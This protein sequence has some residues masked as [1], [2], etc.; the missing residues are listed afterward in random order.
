[1]RRPSGR[2]SGSVAELLQL[3]PLLDRRPAELS[4]GQQ[5]R[6]A[7]ARALVKDA[8]LVLLDEPLANLDYKLREGLRDELPRLFAD[9]GCTVVYA[10]AEPSEALL[11]GGH[12]ATLH[13]GR[14]TQFGPTGDVYRR[15]VDLTTAQVFSDPPINT[16]AV[17]KQGDRIGLSERRRLERRGRL[18]ALPDGAYTRRAPAASR[19]AGAG[20]AG[21]GV[22]AEGKVLIAEISGSESVMHFE[23][24]GLTWVSQS[25]GVHAFEVGEMARFELDVGACLYFDAGR[26]RV[27]PE[28]RRRGRVMARIGLERLR[29]SYR[30]QPAGD[31]DWAVKRDRPRMADGGAYALLGPSGCGKTTLL[32]IISGLVRPTEGRVVFG[33]VDV[34]ASRPTS[35]TSRRCSS[36]RSSTTR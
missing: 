16:A 11:L 22:D 15:P 1:M 13:E 26:G 31:A 17:V 12:T 24:G 25:H 36:F 9:R 20:A 34:T 21:S 23:L 4:G 29:H 5:Q 8:D 14:I 7:L 6:T 2:A 18:R 3:A 35:A 10:T 30:A 33:D 19:A 27:P 32:N 28:M